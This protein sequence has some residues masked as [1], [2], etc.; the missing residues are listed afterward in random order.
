MK[1]KNIPTLVAISVISWILVN[2][3]HEILGHALFGI[4]SGLKLKAVN[5]TTAYLDVNWEKEIAQN[6]FFRLRFTLLGGVLIN[7]LTGLIT[8]LVLKHKKR[9]NSQ[10]HLFL[11]LFTSFSYIIIVMNLVTAPILGG[12]DI[13]GIIRTYDTQGPV[14]ITVLFIGLIIMVLAYIF[15]QK[16]FMPYIKGHRSVLF[17]ITAISILSVIIIQTLSLLMS[18]FAF[19]QPSQNHLLASVFMYFHFLLWALI[20]NIIPSSSK[21]NSIDKLLSDKSMLW[22]VIALLVSIFYIFILGSGIGSFEG[23]PSL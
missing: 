16:S 3:F 6:G 8:Y 11:W 2:V 19:L 15:L 7:F 4:L 18:P 23:H 21:T 12:G 20:V 13:A 10:M 1:R 17:T 14:R 22:I 9:L 5:T